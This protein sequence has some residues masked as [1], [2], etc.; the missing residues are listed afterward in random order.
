M[1]RKHKGS[2]ANWKDQLKILGGRTF[3]N[4]YRNPDLLLTHY[5]I[6]IVMAIVCGLLYWKVD[7]TL[8]GFQNRLGVM[9]FICALFG[10]GCLSSMQSFA[11][12]RLIFL[13]ERANRY[14]SPGTFFISKVHKDSF[15]KFLDSF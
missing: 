3:K 9:F 12:E 5:A 11:T 4:L 10:F 6:S 8:S 7:D 13:R 15:I 14:Y 2:G 1:G